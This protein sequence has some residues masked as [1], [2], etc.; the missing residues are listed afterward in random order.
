[1]SV[2]ATTKWLTVCLHYNEPWEEFLVKAVK[3]YIDVVM[4]TG[5]ADRFYFRRNWERGPHIRL[6]FKGNAY[7][8]EHML[9]P[10][11]KEHFLH[12]FESRPSLLVDPQYPAGFPEKY[13]WFPNNSVQFSTDEPQLCRLG[14]RIEM[15][16]CEKQCQASAHIALHILKETA[17]KWNYNEMIST[18]IKLHLGFAYAIG[19][20]MEEA[21]EFFQWVTENWVQQLEK[22]E[23][24]NGKSTGKE[25]MLRSFHK[26]FEIQKKDIVPY[27][28][29]LWELFKNFRKIDDK[30]FVK[31]L[32]VC[33]SSSLELGYAHNSSKLVSRQMDSLF[34]NKNNAEQALWNF[35]AEFIRL[36]NNQLGITNKNEGY[37]F[38]VISQSLR[39]LKL[40]IPSFS[41]VEA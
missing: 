23:V 20:S 34:D 22:S 16:L 15:S 17:G 40:G 27:H 6:W 4:Q 25:A 26:I 19:F 36:V 30:E 14:G 10:N 7:V 9:L 13:K 18:A 21:Q 38:Y 39:A 11:L 24:K 8:L 29:A 41:K 37:L 2:K 5:V 33:S 35:Y 3:P 28:A 32:H 1:M 31:W 12:Y